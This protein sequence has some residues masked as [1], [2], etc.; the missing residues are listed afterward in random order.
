MNPVVLDQIVRQQEEIAELRQLLETAQEATLRACSIIGDMHA[1]A[2]GGFCTPQL[3]MVEDV[4]Q[5]R[6]DYLTLV[7]VARA[8]VERWDTP[9][10]KDV[11]ATA[12]YIN[13]LRAAIEGEE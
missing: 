7:T 1:A 3:G 13:A 10:W 9:A 6:N 12:G 8:V 2:V 5:L 11:P 4:L